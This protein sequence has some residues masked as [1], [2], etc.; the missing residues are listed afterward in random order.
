M[1]QEETGALLKVEQ[2]AAIVNAGTRTVW[3]WAA[4]GI[5]PKP[6]SLGRSK[7]WLRREVEAWLAR[8]CPKVAR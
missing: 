4:L 7:R 6:V 1:L 2:V 5:L 3:R 8:R